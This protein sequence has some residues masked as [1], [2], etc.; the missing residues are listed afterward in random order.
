MIFSSEQHH[1]VFRYCMM[2]FC[3]GLPLHPRIASLALVIA[4]INEILAGNWK[5]KI[6]G[7]AHPVAIASFLFYALFLFGL[8]YSENQTS[9]LSSLETKLPFLVC[10]LLFFTRSSFEDDFF[11][12]LLKFFIWVAL[13]PLFSALGV[14]F[15]HSSKQV[16]LP[17][18]TNH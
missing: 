14:P 5:E 2:L 6:K 9:A 13:Q 17:F 3:F 7:L 1:A 16:H 10:P 4:L 11:K 8:A 12:R 18:S 15:L